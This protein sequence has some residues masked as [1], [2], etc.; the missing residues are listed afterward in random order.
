M[1]RLRALGKAPCAWQ[2]SVRLARLLALGKAPCAWQGS[3]RLARL[4]ALGKAA[5][6]WQ[7]SL[8]LARLRALGKAPCA[9]QGSL[10]FIANAISYALHAYFL[11][12]KSL[13]KDEKECEEKILSVSQLSLGAWMPHWEPHATDLED[14]IQESVHNTV[15]ARVHVD[16]IERLHVY[17]PYAPCFE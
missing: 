12:K 4:L 14:K 7:G 11:R 10:R 9:W 2:G 3:V 1:A 16:F 15:F 5:C 13:C 17:M 6:A 8:R